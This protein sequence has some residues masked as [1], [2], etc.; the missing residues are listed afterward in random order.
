MFFFLAQTLNFIIK[1]K[2]TC[3]NFITR[4]NYHS[5]AFQ[6]RQNIKPQCHVLIRP[7]IING[8]FRLYWPLKALSMSYP[9]CNLSGK[10]SA[11]PVEAADLS[12]DTELEFKDWHYA[13]L[14]LT[15]INLIELEHSFSRD[16]LFPKKERENINVFTWR[17]LILMRDLKVLFIQ[18]VNFNEK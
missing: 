17:D 3:S 7:G 6:F 14:W 11:S 10:L 4:P 12:S 8:N 18:K 16:S 13:N 15:L 5:T 1:T 2:R 9:P